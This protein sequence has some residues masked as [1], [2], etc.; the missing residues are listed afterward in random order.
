MSPRAPKNESSFWQLLA[1]F[2][3]VYPPSTAL[4]KG[5][6]ALGRATGVDRTWIAQFNDSFTHFWNTHEWTRRGITP[7]V[8]ALQGVPVG[9]IPWVVERLQKREPVI[10]E[11]VDH[12]S[13]IGVELQ[14]ELQRQQ[15]K[16]SIALPLCRDGHLIGFFGYD[17]VS[18]QVGWAEQDRALLKRA[19]RY[20]CPLVVKERRGTGTGA[21]PLVPVPE[22]V[23][24]VRHSRAMLGLDT[25]QIIFIRTD[26]EFSEIILT[27]GRS[28]RV[29]RSLRSWES[30][31]PPRMFVRVSNQH[32][33]RTDRV[34]ELKK[35]QGRSWHISVRDWVDL[36][37][38]GTQHFSFLR[39]LMAVR[40]AGAQF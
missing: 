37:P 6:A 31:L 10:I 25:A 26:G 34:V 7:F 21:P 22:L 20:F 13:Q 9:M 4:Q 29:L 27:H 15:I 38:V 28:Y 18:R 24:Y 2:A 8:D 40:I 3:A 23:I 30:R 12:M 16:S 1:H 11:D 17:M 5:L 39:S 36:L 35:G 14:A 32:L 33:V 19:S